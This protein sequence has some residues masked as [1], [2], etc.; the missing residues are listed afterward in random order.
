MEHTVTAKDLSQYL[1]TSGSTIIRT[2][3]ETS[4]D[5]IALIDLNT[6][7]LMI[8]QQGMELAGYKNNNA[9]DIIGRSIL[10]FIAPKD[11][12]Q[13][14]ENILKPVETGSIRNF[15][16]HALKKDGTQ[17]P[18]ELSASLIVD[19]GGKPR[20][21]MAVL[22]D[23]TE[24]KRAEMEMTVLQE[25][26]H[27]SQRMEAIGQ[28][29]GDIA[30]DFGNL[31][32][33][34]KGYT[35]L[36][37]HTLKGDDPLQ[38]NIKEIQKATERATALV[39]TLLDFSHHQVMEMKVLDLNTL[40][41]DLDKMLH[42]VISE[43]IKLVMRLAED[44]GKVKV[45]PKNIEQVILNLV[46]NARD[47]MPSGG[48]L[49]IETAN[50]ELDE[51]YARIHIPTKPGSFVMLSVG[52]TG[53]GMTP[54]VKERIFEPFFTTKENGKGTG[55][56]LSNVYRLIKQSRGNIWV[57]SKPEKGTTFEIY[58]PRVDESLKGGGV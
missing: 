23:I 25:Q 16:C 50:V 54:E 53:D 19:K 18:V 49:F 47:A 7:I 41:R 15:Q 44:L 34:I 58:L 37:F 1:K 29:A 6:N 46:V 14:A 3:V 38:D 10:E 57:Y 43:D 8:N 21:L 40:L 24:R 31:L 56:G 5:A 22:R 11:R 33:I 13:V 20:A 32:S 27:Q 51:A 2:L 4:P 42:Q 12:S 36:S 17:C 9:G 48:K 30:H 39:R 28:L 55:L 35:N 52:D 26:L 45:D